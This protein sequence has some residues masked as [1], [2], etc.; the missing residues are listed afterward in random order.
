MRL[1]P[2]PPRRSNPIFSGLVPLLVFLFGAAITLSYWSSIRRN[3][4]SGQR[5]ELD[6][7][8]EQTASL[9]ENSLREIE[10]ALYSA[11]LMAARGAVETP[12]DWRDFA[13]GMNQFLQGNVWTWGYIERVPRPEIDS[14]EARIRETAEPDFSAARAGTGP[15]AY[16]VLATTENGGETSELGNDIYLDPVR[17]AAADQ[18]A[19][20]ASA[21]MSGRVEVAIDGTREQGALLLLPIYRAA[22]PPADP[23]QR[24][25][26]L[27]GWVYAEVRL[28][29]LL[30]LALEASGGPATLGIF[31]GPATNPGDL[32]FSA[33]AYEFSE[34]LPRDSAD[35]RFGWS[36][37]LYG[38]EWFLS[39]YAPPL[40]GSGTG[41]QL[42]MI[43]L[44]GGLGLSALAGG[45]TS[46]M[47]RSRA[48]A[49]ELA[50]E[51]TAS[52]R[53][54]ETRARRL[55][56]VAER[57]TGSVMI[58]GPDWRIEWVNESFTRL[59]GYQSG[60]VIGRLPSGLLAGPDTSPETIRA[61]DDAAR[62][63]RSFKGEMVNYT[64]L[65]QP[66]WIQL[67]IQPLLGKAGVLEG[68]MTLQHDITERRRF[69]E[70]LAR[71]EAQFRFIF[72]LV[73]VGLSWQ[74]A[75][76]PSSLIVNSA[77]TRI[78]GVPPGRE[79]DPEE[80]SRG[81]SEEDYLRYARL[82]A[83]LNR[84]EIDHF[85]LE[86][87]RV[88]PEGNSAWHVRTVRNF[89]D[90]TTREVQQ[91]AT[92]I[93]VTEL[94]QQALE[95]QN[96][97]ESAEQANK[98]KS[99]FLAMVSHE[100]RT[101]MNGVIGM[102]SLLLETE[103]VAEQREYV[104]IIRQSGD[105]LLAVINDILDFSKIESGHME[106]EYT[107]FPLEEC[108]ESVVGLFASQFDHK[109]L[110]FQLIRPPGLPDVICT[111]PVRLRQILVNLLGNA[112]KFTAQGSIRLEVEAHSRPEDRFELK[113]SVHDTGI[114]IPPE[115][116]PRLF[117]SFSQI[118][119]STTRRFGGTGLGLAISKR[120]AELLGGTM[121]VE[122]VARQGSTFHFT[123]LTQPLPEEV[124]DLPLP[125]AA[126]G[127]LAPPR[128]LVVHRD[129]TERR[130]LVSLIEGW[131]LSA[132]AV[133]SGPEAIAALKL[134]QRI[135]AA[136]LD[137]QLPDM[138][139]MRLAAAIRHLEL[140]APLRLILMGNAD[141]EVSNPV[142]FASELPESCSPERLHSALQ[143]LF[144]GRLKP[145]P[146]FDSTPPIPV[147]RQPQRVLLAED[148][149]VNQK[150]AI[151]ML[152]RL[153]FGVDI[154]A[155]G[156]AALQALQRQ[157]YDILLLD[158]QMPELD[159]LQTAREIRK[160]WGDRPDRPWIIALTANAMQG[161]RQVCL[162]A[163]M[164]DYLSKPVDRDELARAMRRAQR[165]QSG[166]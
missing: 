11:R 106:I 113:F 102:T 140:S 35:S 64:K 65:G 29:R 155:D 30:T 143:R 120:L 149:E 123:I 126:G 10:Q 46:I 148:N 101:P 16:L 115:A 82:L 37:S 107:A 144:P 84:G 27:Q 9:M 19:Q 57:T 70:E 66:R 42:S 79:A 34:P 153:G 121:W 130:R 108:L 111:D 134:N 36:L 2:R 12:A 151:R 14:V 150:V 24:A 110:D 117:Q 31:A 78:S 72:D 98:A 47:L 8:A 133:G 56:L 40:G 25:A 45:L 18:A 128:I 94:K 161:D 159:G 51:M 52:L 132:Q 22:E 131:G 15:F 68:F 6:R 89:T 165:R 74:R 38:R 7:R 105:A 152:D 33:A 156:K 62:E 28:S 73:P 93:D 139:E 118:D 119:A 4:A 67:E 157:P 3:L 135:D 83:R 80:A 145:L 86:E 50:Q 127:S 60:E 146:R 53:Q 71:K 88:D 55:A 114:G 1:P 138:Q 125:A 129:L 69:E 163:G 158:V 92:L 59:F 91:V 23:E 142:S 103:L 41:G 162:D 75:G 136:L 54:T 77:W 97:M 48:R 44:F 76:D 104:E 112:I 58:C 160:E 141:P 95:L 122:S 90:P 116:M 87:R 32:E 61:I 17:S 166:N 20:S 99:Q 100:I 154:V 164:D 49:L 5:L 63:Q 96:A 39:L 124:R 21:A 147:P 13:A 26:L 81:L 43:M 137:A 109:Q 85:T